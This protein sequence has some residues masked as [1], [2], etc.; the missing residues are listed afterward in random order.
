MF[1]I[2]HH[3]LHG[4][5]QREAV[6]QRL[7]SFRSG[8]ELQHGRL[9]APRNP[10][11]GEA[12]DE[13]QRRLDMH[14]YLVAAANVVAAARSLNKFYGDGTVS[15]AIQ[16]VETAAPLVRHFRDMLEHFE[17]YDKGVGNL[18]RS[19]D[20]PAGRPVESYTF[21]AKDASVEAYGARF[22]IATTTPTIVGLADLVARLKLPRSRW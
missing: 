10:A 8:V 3:W 7:E 16:K 6:H 5:D 4:S 17:A 15:N 11:T 9:L 14:F 20:W 18:Q 13:V 21:S 22:S 2:T 12:E 19:G 1:A